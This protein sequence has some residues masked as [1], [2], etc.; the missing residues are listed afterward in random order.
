MQRVHDRFVTRVVKPAPSRS[1]LG[2]GRMLIGLVLAILSAGCASNAPEAVEPGQWFSA[3]GEPVS[4]K[5]VLA[6]FRDADIILLGEVHD[7]RPVHRKQLALLRGVEGPV[8]LALEQLDLRGEA[9]SAMNAEVDRHTARE[10]AERGGFDF[11]AWG[12]ANYAGLFELATARRWPLWPLNLPRSKAI[13]VAMAGD[14]GWR[15]PL[16]ASEVE[17]IE[18]LGTA[19]SLS[20][21]ATGRLVEDLQQAHCGQI[22]AAMAQGMARAQVARDILMADALVRARGRY[23]AH[24]VIGVMGNQHARH[25]RG[26]PYW[27]ERMATQ[28]AGDVIAIG[29][30]PS[31]SFDTLS[32]AASAYD[33]VWITE[34]VERDLGCEPSS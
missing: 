27:L 5:A 2:P 14:G 8:V 24:R 34:P 19:P 21:P 29:M 20:K 7:S 33:F 3:K 23:P 13:A 22:D 17:A 6:R 15:E 9:A 31:D 1:F 12:W 18:R 28:S 16:E 11:D 4:Q 25:D 32:E 30:L 26:V 10:R